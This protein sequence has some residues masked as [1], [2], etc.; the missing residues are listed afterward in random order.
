MPEKPALRASREWE[1]WTLPGADNPPRWYARTFSALF[2]HRL[3]SH[4]IGMVLLLVAIWW[5]GTFRPAL[6]GWRA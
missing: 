4:A 2:V 5:L 6:P 3:T 1:Q